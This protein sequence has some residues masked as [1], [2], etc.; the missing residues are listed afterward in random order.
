MDLTDA[1]WLSSQQGRLL[2]ERLATA[3]PVYDATLAMRLAEGLRRRGINPKAAAASL[4]QVRLRLQGQAKFGD[5]ASQMLFT[6]VGLEQ[7]TRLTVAVH[8][9]QRYR[10]AGCHRVADL[11]GGI[12]GDALALAGLG[13]RV[14]VYESDPP[15]AAIA[16][17]NLA[18]FP[19]ARVILGDALEQDLSLADAI[20]ADP[21]RRTA[22]G[23]RVF[24]PDAY[25]PPLRA[26]LAL[27]TSHPLGVKVGPGIPHSAIPEDAEA[28][29]VSVD[30]TVVEAGLWFGPLRQ[31]GLKP[32]AR[33][34]TDPAS[35]TSQTSGTEPAYSALVIR[36]GRANHLLAGSLP[37]LPVGQLRRYIYEPDGAVIRAGLLPEAA[38]ALGPANLVNSRIAYITSDTELAS[39]PFLTGYEVK[40]TLP[41][42]L[43][44]LRTYLRGHGIGQL[45]VKKRGTAVDPV[46]LRKR[47]GLNGPASAVVILTRLGAQQSV[48]IVE[49]LARS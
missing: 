7:A 20:Y 28:Q 38:T 40:D 3:M 26:I 8:H 19:E 21:S 9:A 41:F 42:N 6:Q 33:T 32:A 23:Q 36:S 35:G 37:T 4:T 46:D 45:T 25:N 43:K 39:S 48:L 13:L 29:W 16:Q 34:P 18:A 12:G 14:D 10:L 17:S 27:R 11:T 24:Q 5:F 2:T 49:P 22:A 47:L 15:T 44:H 31:A 1:V 30:G